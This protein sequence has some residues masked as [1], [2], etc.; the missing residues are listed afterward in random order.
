MAAL[1]AATLKP[2]KILGLPDTG[3]PSRK[4]QGAPNL[5]FWT[6]N[7]LPGHKGTPENFNVS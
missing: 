7:L 4:G 2:G 3:K 5:G 6:P 1:Q